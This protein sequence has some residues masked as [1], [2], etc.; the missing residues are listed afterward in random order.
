MLKVFVLPFFLGGGVWA[1]GLSALKFF[2]GLSLIYRMRVT[3][4]ILDN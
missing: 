3:L 4:C 2:A 1:S